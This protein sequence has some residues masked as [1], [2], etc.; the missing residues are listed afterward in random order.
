MELLQ[1]VNARHRVVAMAKL[2]VHLMVAVVHAK[3]NA[4]HGVLQVHT[5]ILHIVAQAVRM[6]LVYLY[7]E[8]INANVCHQGE[9]LVPVQLTVLLGKAVCLG[10]AV[11]DLK[12]VIGIIWIIKRPC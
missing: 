3:E 4:V 10:V 7:Q 8:I 1:L 9:I 11:Q 12:A 5:R 6:L 2:A